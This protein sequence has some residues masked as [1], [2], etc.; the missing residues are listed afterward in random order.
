M[1]D[2]RCVDVSAAAQVRLTPRIYDGMTW[3][4]GQTINVRIPMAGHPT[5]SVTWLKDGAELLTEDG[6]REVWTEDGCAVVNISQC[7][8]TV[9]RG[10][11]GIRVEN[12]LGVDEASF[13]VEITSKTSFSSKK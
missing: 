9:D 1:I 12:S 7:R 3:S 5:P 2:A 4:E 11:Y 8:R 10:V 6:R 13:A